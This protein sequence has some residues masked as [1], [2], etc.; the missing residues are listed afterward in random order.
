MFKL[1]N[2]RICADL[3]LCI[4]NVYK[5][6]LKKTLLQKLLCNIT[7]LTVCEQAFSKLAADLVPTMYSSRRSVMNVFT[8]LYFLHCTCAVPPSVIVMIPTSPRVASL[9]SSWTS[10]YRFSLLWLCCSDGGATIW[11]HYLSLSAA[12]TVYTDHVEGGQTWLS[13]QFRLM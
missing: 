4:Q 11:R 5:V 13:I 6:R 10:W 3:R 12:C 2:L 7:C 8:F 1:T 9:W